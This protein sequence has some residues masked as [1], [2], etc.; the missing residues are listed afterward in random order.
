MTLN[1][2]HSQD[3]TIHVTQTTEKKG[4]IV[5][6]LV[7]AMQK[8]TKL[9]VLNFYYSTSKFLL[10]QNSEHVFNF[11]DKYMNNV[12]MVLLILDRNE[13]FKREQ[14]SNSKSL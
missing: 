7:P 4:A 13:H 3:F 1:N 12:L 14:Y 8:E 10:N 2:L 11:A 9:F 6:E 5:S